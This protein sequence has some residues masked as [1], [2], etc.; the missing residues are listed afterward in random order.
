MSSVRFVLLFVVMNIS[1]AC[2]WAETSHARNS[3]IRVQGRADVIVTEP[4]IRL[5][6]IAHIESASVSDDEKIVQLRTLSLGKSPRAGDSAVIDGVSILEQM[7]SAGIRL[8]SVLYSFPRQVKVTRAFREVSTEELEKALHSFLTSKE[9][10]LDIKKIVMEK[11]VRIP[12]DSFGVEVVGLETTKPGHIGVDYRTVAGSDETRFQMKA[13][14][15]EWRL[16]PV[17]TKPL[18]KGD[19]V[20]AADVQLTRINGVAVMRDSVEQ[21]GDI[22]GKTVVRDVGEGE[23]FQ[24]KSLFVPPVISAGSRVSILYRHG[25]LEA[26]AAGIALESGA[27]HQDIKVRNE[28]S[29]KVVTARVVDKGLVEVGAH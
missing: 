3:S 19:V 6:D 10:H 24:A 28:S 20:G 15:D 18:K 25:R 17:A 16:M 22:V 21:L 5:G 12:T 1:G 14:A 7:R 4:E 9:K 29:Q 2:A 13:L 23:M 11:P 26:S 8:D 27:A